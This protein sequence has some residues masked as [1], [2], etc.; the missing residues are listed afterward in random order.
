MQLIRQYHHLIMDNVAVLRVSQKYAWKNSCICIISPFYVYFCC[1]VKLRNYLSQPQLN[2]CFNEK[3]VGNSKIYHLQHQ[4][5]DSTE[6][7]RTNGL[8]KELTV[9]DRGFKKG[10]YCENPRSTLFLLESLFVSVLLTES[11]CF[12]SP[13]YWFILSGVD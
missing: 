5:Y 13:Q 7:S 9:T 4:V 10:I 12:S 11:Y 3:T 2:L 1:C 6:S 8:H